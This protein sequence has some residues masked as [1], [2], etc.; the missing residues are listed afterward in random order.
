MNAT[1]VSRMPP[2][3]DVALGVVV[4]PRGGAPQVREV[5]VSQRK[6]DQVLAGM[7]EFPG[8]KVEAGETPAQC[9][10]R[11][12]REEVGLGVM[13]QQPLARIS[14]TYDHAHVRLR[15]F[16]CAWERGEAQPLQVAQCRWVTAEELAALHFPPANAPLLMWLRGYLLAGGQGL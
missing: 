11:E 5:L 4:R 3:V 12:L 6:Q 10:V 16:L 7:W 9:V 15:P 13:V 8:G 2:H 1:P 14:H